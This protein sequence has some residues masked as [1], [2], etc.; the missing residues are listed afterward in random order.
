MNSI[1]RT[2]PILIVV[3]SS[4]M[5]AGHTFS[6]TLSGL[7]RPPQDS[8]EAERVRIWIPVERDS[9]CRVDIKIVD[10]SGRVVRHLLNYRPSRGYYN[11]YW[12]KRDDSGKRVPPGTYY[13]MVDNCG[14][15]RRRPIEAR[16]GEWEKASRIVLPDT[17]RPFLVRFELL[18]DSADVSVRILS[19]RGHQVDS[20]FVDSI[21]N[22]GQHEIEWQPP[23]SF[24]H[25]NYMIEVTIGEYVYVRE[26]SYLP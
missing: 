17:A 8:A 14:N 7:S 13:S 21:F 5:M 20:V 22:K 18:E 25:G 3:I 24:R 15:I 10:D 1:V 9:K 11:Y 16:Y 12:D 2:L 26:V 6:Q 23:P 4:L 19:Q